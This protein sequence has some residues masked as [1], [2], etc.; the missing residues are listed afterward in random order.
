M[1]KKILFTIQVWAVSSSWIHLTSRIKNT[2]LRFTTRLLPQFL[3]SFEYKHLFMI[4]LCATTSSAMAATGVLEKAK[5]MQL[6]QQYPNVVLVEHPL[7]QH[8]LSLM[9]DKTT[10]T[11][12]FRQLLREISLL[13]G[14]EVTRDFPI[15]HKT[16]DTPLESFNAPFV[17]GKKVAVVPVLRAGLGMS[18]GLLELIPSARVGH[19]GLYRDEKTKKPVEYFVK[20]PA[21]EDRTFIVVDPMLATG[22]SLAYAIDTLNKRGVPDERIRVMTLL[23]A[24]EGIKKMAEAHPKVKIYTSSIDRQLNNVSFI[25]PGLGDAGD[26]LFGTK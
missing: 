8:K 17:A 6:Q 18:E 20:I 10:S 3:N 24:P 9:R 22:G 13:M 12:Q 7:I 23:S 14:Y 5:V 1:Y 2:L 4:V 11:N 26:R 15:V 21:G 19:I 16:I 25:M